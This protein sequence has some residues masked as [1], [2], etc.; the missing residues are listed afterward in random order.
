MRPSATT[1]AT[2]ASPRR[3]H[4]TRAVTRALATLATAALLLGG[5]VACGSDDDGADTTGAKA[6]NTTQTP[7]TTEPTPTD[8]VR[9]AGDGV[10]PPGGGPKI[11]NDFGRAPTTTERAAIV[12]AVERYHAAVAADDDARICAQMSL[13]G[14]RQLTRDI[15]GATPADCAEHVGIIYSGFTDAIRASLRHTRIHELRVKGDHALVIGIVPGPR[16]I[17]LPLD[18]D[19]GTWRYGT[20]GRWTSSVENL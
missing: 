1:H 8:D 4:R 20:F 9:A 12:A 6:T 11:L 3:R 15:P 2:K 14:K 13:A 10:T 17:K 18:R 5:L 19:G 7:T 16:T